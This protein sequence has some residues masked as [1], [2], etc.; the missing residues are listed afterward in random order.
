MEQFTNSVAQKLD[1]GEMVLK[2]IALRQSASPSPW[3]MDECRTLGETIK[4]MVKRGE[5]LTPEQKIKLA[6]YM[7]EYHTDYK[8]I[9][10]KYFELIDSAQR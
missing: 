5:L 8:Q 4:G 6:N 9:A 2:A 7:L 1:D 10:R 3:L